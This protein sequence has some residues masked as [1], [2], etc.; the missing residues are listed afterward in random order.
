MKIVTPRGT[1][2]AMNKIG[3]NGCQIQAELKWNEQFQP[4]WEGKFNK[5]Q[6]YVDNECLR[7][8]DKLIPFQTGFLK[9]SGILGTI[10]G[11]GELEYLSPYSRYQY[12]GKV[13]V[14]H[15]PKRVTNIPLKYNHAPKRGSF[16]FERMKVQHKEQ[17]LK[18]AAKLMRG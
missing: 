12:Y 15:P 7:H 10:V 5:A 8:S 14:G 3:K 16:W 13:M 17:I 18:G 1:L 11:S 2:F 9:K 6:K 4:D